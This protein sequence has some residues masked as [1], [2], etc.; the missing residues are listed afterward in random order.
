MAPGEAI[1]FKIAFFM[2]SEE[3]FVVFPK[4]IETPA[5]ARFCAIS[6]F[7]SK[8]KQYLPIIQHKF[9]TVG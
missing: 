5:F 7:Y 9:Y 8:Q 2:S 3:T 4:Y 1:N 6:Y